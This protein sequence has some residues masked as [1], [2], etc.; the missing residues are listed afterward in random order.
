MESLYY[1]QQ[2]H[3]QQE[4]AYP[5]QVASAPVSAALLPWF[6]Q[7]PPERVGL[8]GEYDHNGLAKRVRQ[9]LER[10]LTPE[11]VKALKITQ[12]G[13]VVV[14]VS[15]SR[16]HQFLNRVVQLVLPVEGVTGIELNGSIVTG[17]GLIG[18]G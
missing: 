16:N 15:Q 3:F 8:F 1:L 18:W 6:K 5:C 11:E 12:R 9:T 10:H 14:L 13:G 4:T 2:N 7:I 17:S